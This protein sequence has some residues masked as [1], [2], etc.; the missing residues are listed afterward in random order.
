MLQRSRS[1]KPSLAEI[2]DVGA[3]CLMKQ[4]I[5][6]VH[7]SS[8]AALVLLTIG[9]VTSNVLCVIACSCR[10]GMVAKAVAARRSLTRLT[11]QL[12]THKPVTPHGQAGDAAH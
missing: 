11:Q 3:E 7:I 2:A 12:F 4:L 9:L 6:G 5:Q 1:W 10:S 8:F